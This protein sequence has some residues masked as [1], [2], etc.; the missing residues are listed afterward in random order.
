MKVDKKH[1]KNFMYRLGIDGLSERVRDIVGKRIFDSEIVRIITI[2]AEEGF[3]NFKFFFIFSYSFENEYDFYAFEMLIHNL[4]ESLAH[5][6]RPV[7][8]RLKFTP[9]VPQE[10]TPMENF[11]PYYSQEMKD[12]IDNWFLSQKMS[13]RLSGNLVIIND[14]V[15]EKKNYYA[16]AYLHRASFEDVQPQMLNNENQFALIHAPK[17][18]KLPKV[19]NLVYTHLDKSV[20]GK[21]YQKMLSKIKDSNDKEELTDYHSQLKNSL[22]DLQDNI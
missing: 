1:R 7:F 22:N 13:K 6:K 2:M 16:Q 5:L 12:R 4:R 11:A 19:T 8:L 14:G 15:M 20:R 3:V 9:F 10:L 18:L 17:L 21:F